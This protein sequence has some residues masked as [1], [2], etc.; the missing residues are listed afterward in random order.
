[1]RSRTVQN[2]HSSVPM[3]RVLWHKVLQRDG[4][5]NGAQRRAGCAP[6]HKLNAWTVTHRSRAIPL[7]LFR[8]VHPHLA[9]VQTIRCLWRK[10]LTAVCR[11][12][13]C[14][15]PLRLLAAAGTAATT[16][17]KSA[18]PTLLRARLRRA[19]LLRA[20]STLMDF[21]ILCL[22][23]VKARCLTTNPSAITFPRSACREMNRADR[24]Q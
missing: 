12:F 9:S 6:I 22:Q 16:Q 13:A 5:M 3:I 23:S 19:A 1:M 10:V 24:M 17:S 14:P 20:L 18:M 4:Y 7:V 2:L 11:L 8:T 21:S 15:E